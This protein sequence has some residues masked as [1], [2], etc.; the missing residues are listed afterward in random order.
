MATCFFNSKLTVRIT[1]QP[2]RAASDDMLREIDARQQVPI[3]APTVQYPD[4]HVHSS[5]FPQQPQ[6]QNQSP[7]SAPF[8]SLP[9]ASQ[10]APIIGPVGRDPAPHAIPLG[11]TST[12]ATAVIPPLPLPM[13][14]RHSL[15]HT[16]LVQSNIPSDS[17]DQLP[18]TLPAVGAM[19]LKPNPVSHYRDPA[20]W[21]LTEV[22]YIA[23]IL[24][25]MSMDSTNFRESLHT[26]MM[27]MAKE[28]PKVY[29][30]SS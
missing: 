28:I 18:L 30:V 4:Q 8:V 15:T 29:R 14:M 5:Y 27:R 19:L 9:S 1:E 26:Y 3:S 24:T 22:K 12:D 16:P 25:W 10:V 7:Q 20:G 13:P 21:E 23:D 6:S 17:I 11:W 2:H